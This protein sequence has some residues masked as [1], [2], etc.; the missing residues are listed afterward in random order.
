MDIE[1]L[2]LLQKELPGP[3]LGNQSINTCRQIVKQTQ[4]VC[5]AVDMDQAS[6][7]QKENHH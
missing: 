5:N 6:S 2:S 1:Y 7:Q 3:Y 4:T